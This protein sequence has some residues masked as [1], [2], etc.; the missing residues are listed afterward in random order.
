GTG[1]NDYSRT[2]A[3]TVF[4]FPALGGMLFGYDIGG[5]SAVLA[6]L[7]STKLSGVSW[8]AYVQ[9]SSVLQGLITSNGVLGAM[10]GSLIC[11]R[12]GDVI[13]RKAELL[14]ASGLFLAGALVEGVSG[15]R[16]WGAGLGITVLL[17]GRVIYGLGCG[18]AMHGAPAYIGEM[19]PSAVRGLLVSLKEAMI[20]VGMLLGYFMGWCLSSQV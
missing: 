14:I 18:F 15:H 17:L 7:E 5:T 11:F 6:Q 9:D 8:S 4:F 10:I 19:A 20:V 13:G 2:A 1:E 3:F 16:S 12:V